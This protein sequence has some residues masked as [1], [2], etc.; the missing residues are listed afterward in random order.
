MILKKISNEANLNSKFKVMEKQTAPILLRYDGAKK[1][2][3]EMS[4]LKLIQAAESILC[5][6][7]EKVFSKERPIY[8]GEGDKVMAE[9]PDGH[10]EKVKKQG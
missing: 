5:R 10:I 1:S 6:A 9:Y 2:T 7:K 8:F 3:F 4:Q